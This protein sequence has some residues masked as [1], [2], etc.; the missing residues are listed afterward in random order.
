MANTIPEMANTTPE[1]AIKINNDI[2]NELNPTQEHFLKKY[3]L[4]NRLTHELHLLSQ[5]NCCQLFGP[6][7][8]S[9]PEQQEGYQFPLLRFFFNNFIGTFPFIASNKPEDQ[10]SF[11]QDTV[12]EFLESFN[13]KN[14][15]DSQ[16]RQDN[17]TKRRQINKKMLSSLLLFFN[18]ML[19]TGQDLEYL[20]NEHLKPSETGALDKIRK[21]PSYLENGVSLEDFGGLDEYEK[22]KFTNDLNLN[23]VAVK[24]IKEQSGSGSDSAGASR[25]NIFKEVS[26]LSPYS[27]NPGRH[28]YEF[29]IHFTKREMDKEGIYHYTSYFIPRPYHDFKKLEH[30]LKKKYPGLMSTDVPKLPQKLKRDDGVL[31]KRDSESSQSLPRGD[32][33]DTL[34]NNSH[35]D[36]SFKTA[37]TLNS[38]S[39]TPEQPQSLA[40]ERLRLALRSY[41]NNLIKHNEIIHSDVFHHFV[42]NPHLQYGKLSPTEVHDYENRLQHEKAKAETQFEFQKQTANAILELGKNFDEFKKKLIMNPEALTEIFEE[43]GESPKVENLSP[44]LKTFVEWSKLEVAATLY[45]VFLSVDNSS[46]WLLKCRKFHA[47]FPYNIVYGILKFTNPMKIVSRIIDLLLANFPSFSLPLFGFSSSKEL[48]DAS[49][50]TKARNLLSLMFIMLLDE[51][52]NDFKKELKNLKEEK[53][54]GNMKYEPFLQRI[55]NYVIIADDSVVEGIKEHSR[56]S[57][58]DLLLTLLSTDNLEPVLNAQDQNTYND[59]ARSYESYEEINDKEKLSESELYFNLKQYWL[60]L[61]RKKDKDLMKQ[62]WQEPELT[63]LIKKFLTIFY[64]PLMRVFAKCDIHLVFKDFQRFMD[65]L[66]NELTQLSE[67]DMYYMSPFEIFERSRAVFDR[68]ENALWGFI[69]NLYVKDDEKLFLNIIKWIEKFLFML[70]IKFTDPPK[71]TINLKS[72]MPQDVDQ[73]LLLQQLNQKISKTLQKRAILKQYL[74]K[75]A[76]LDEVVNTQ[77]A[78]DDQWNYV[79]DGMLPEISGGDFGINDDDIDDFNLLHKETEANA[80]SALDKDLH[81][82]LSKL[83]KELDAFGTSEIDKFDD[84]LRTHL[85]ELLAKIQ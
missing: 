26:R 46:E 50:S 77:N 75:K 55:E 63:R 3:L 74:N 10:L 13:L 32:S 24:H 52:L 34:G 23:I 68:H 15:S 42:F 17:T 71:V 37:S 41:L 36:L 38:R 64:Q 80:D 14:I 60:I 59:I 5:P 49:K 33:F 29:I 67:G 53:L 20:H 85:D 30:D 78:I 62:L 84:L 1:V 58:K 19:I 73:N 8:K 48:S 12:Q 39:A 11:W 66:L 65:D 25:W 4:E 83:E 43:I 79:N 54:S 57:G 82:K 70:R 44:L 31:K 6:P 61:L 40:R 72:A 45:Q 51:D 22:M 2:I 28:N 47:L 7:F 35:D 81:M 18:S 9:T 21:K 27:S 16:E 76:Q 56:D 69:H